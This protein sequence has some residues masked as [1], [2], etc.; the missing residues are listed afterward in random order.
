MKKFLLNE[1]KKDICVSEYTIES[2]D[3]FDDEYSKHFEG[4]FTQGNGYMD[5]RG[6][7]EEGVKSVDQGEEYDRRPAN[8]TL[9]KHKKQ[10]Q[11]WGT[12]VPGIV[13]R[14]PNL[15]TEIINL[16]FFFDSEFYIDGEKID[17]EIVKIKD[18]SYV[19]NMKDGSIRRSFLYESENGIFRF[20][21]FRFLSMNSKHLAI[22]EVKVT[23][24]KGIGKLKYKSGINGHVRT[25][26]F[27]HFTV[28]SS[29]G[30]EDS[31]AMN[32]FTNGDSNVYMKAIL[33]VSEG[34]DKGC[35]KNS[36]RIAYEGSGDIKEGEVFLL[37]KVISVASDKD[38]DEKNDY[39]ERANQALCNLSSDLNDEYKSHLSCFKEKWKASDILIEGNLNLQKALRI[40]IYHLIRSC[41]EDNP[42][43]AICAKGFAGEAYFGR[44][45]WDTEINMLPFF[46][47]T[48]PKAARS[49]IEFRFR[50]LEGAKRNAKAYGYKGARYAWESSVTGDEECMNWQ[51]CDHE[52]HVTADIVY[53]ICHYV[54]ATKDFEFLKDCGAEIMIET[55][56]YWLSRVDKDK[57]GKYVLLGV[58][59]PDE[60]LP[61]T[62]N[63][64]YTNY[65]T[66]F[67]IKATLD[68]L[69][70]LKKNAPNSYQNLVKK[71]GLLE[72]EV[73]QFK[74]LYNNLKISFDKDT[75]I[76]LQC[77]EFLS[78]A[79]V[80]FDKVWQDRS[81]CFGQFISQERNYRSK[82]LK[83]AD[84]LE[85]M[86][87][88]P[89]DFSDKQLKANYE[90]YEPIT[91]HDS[92]L[93]AFVHGL[94]AGK[95][96]K[97][98]DVENFLEKVIET[99]CDYIRKGAEEGIHIANCG[100]LWQLVVF[101][102]AGLE[103]ALWNDEVSFK[104]RLPKGI[105]KITIPVCWKGERKIYTVDN[106]SCISTE[107]VI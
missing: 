3:H 85:M 22:L 53:A 99:D 16:P 7:F 93:S 39:K 8:V 23:A 100:G 48:N 76:I 1:I 81:K 34:F 42:N 27:N 89:N 4:L 19:L 55:A 43:V 83:Q 9:E 73:D 88:F 41:C 54:S 64:V 65:M 59:G 11:K 74:D 107:F 71:T 60:Y 21:F 47:Y 51:Y 6:S 28:L 77:D 45:F 26:G 2:L 15:A 84:V 52:I 17:L 38:I 79:D 14:H 75:D 5:V 30:N 57:E 61:M 63:N 97:E 44:F 90:Y 78:Y 72:S 50:S 24:I 29:E 68:T 32:I 91:T 96:G 104:P 101:G 37:Q 12:Y 67:S 95:L 86:M 102:F 33:A 35:I 105:S 13:G 70:W 46:I 20:E 62:Q 80:D 103:T 66:K 40:S 94:I 82:A 106:K 18:F 69:D 49:L 98:E 36:E 56:R 58:M 10:A 92:S 87:L 31:I 25:N